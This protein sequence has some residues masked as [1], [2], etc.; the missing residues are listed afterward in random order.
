MEKHFTHIEKWSNKFIFSSMC[1]LPTDIRSLPETNA[2][3]FTHMHP[4]PAPVEESC[5]L[6]AENKFNTRVVQVPFDTHALSRDQNVTHS[7]GNR[8]ISIPGDEAGTSFVGSLS[9]GKKVLQAW[10][11]C[12]YGWMMVERLH[13]WD[14]ICQQLAYAD[15]IIQWSIYDRCPKCT[16]LAQENKLFWKHTSR[17]KSSQ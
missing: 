2:E 15:S 6:F 12:L 8:Y 7:I 1:W 4:S 11:L 3:K 9:F 13:A 14:Y 10:S 16:V 17:K 5:F